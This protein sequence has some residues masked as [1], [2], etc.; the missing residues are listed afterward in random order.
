MPT[1]IIVTY[2]SL[3]VLATYS[4]LSLKPTITSP[5][6]APVFCAFGMMYADLKHTYTRPFAS[7]VE[8]ADPGQIS[9]LFREM[10]QEARATLAREGASSAD[11]VIERSIDMH[12]YGQV[13]EQSALVPD[14]PVTAETLAAIP[15]E[16]RGDYLL[17]EKVSYAPALI[18][19]DGSGVKAEVRMMFLCPEDTGRMTLAINLARL[20]RGK[21][22][23]VD[24]NKGLKWVGSSV[25][26]WP[27]EK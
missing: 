5:R 25:A 8:E 27:I 18:A 12:Y 26:I 9:R 19:P 24:H 7:V 22:H 17:Q 2:T 16:K 4:G 11:I 3:K 6:V 20:S 1:Y 15:R 14:G 21:M 10:E 13:R 23:G